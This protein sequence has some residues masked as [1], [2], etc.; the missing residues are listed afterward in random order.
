MPYPPTSV[1][2]ILGE[3][4]IPAVGI[5]ETGLFFHVNNA[6]E[7]AYGWTRAELLGKSV[8]TIIPPAMRELHHIGFSRFLSTETSTLAGRPLPLPILCKDGRVLDAEHFI[9][10]EKKDGQWRLAATINE[11]RTATA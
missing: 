4:D 7:G 3:E 2:E 8:T 6:F 11:K 10:A 5:D 1:E 9:L